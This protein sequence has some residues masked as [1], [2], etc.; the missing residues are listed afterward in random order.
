MAGARGSLRLSWVKY[1]AIA[2]AGTWPEHL[3]GH[4]YPI[5]TE[6]KQLK[7]IGIQHGLRMIGPFGIDET[8]YMS[9]GPHSYFDQYPLGDDLPSTMSH[10]VHSQCGSCG[11]SAGQTGD[12]VASTATKLGWCNS[13]FG[14]PWWAPEH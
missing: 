9:A 1:F 7:E 8:G 12:E 2:H 11:P 4:D 3:Y 10:W 5:L 6:A 13:P 14:S